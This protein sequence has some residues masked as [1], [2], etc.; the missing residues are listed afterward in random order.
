MLTDGGSSSSF[1]LVN[2]SFG[3]GNA[4]YMGMALVMRGGFN[5]T[6][7]VCSFLNSGPTTNG[8][9]T[10]PTLFRRRDTAGNN[11]PGKLV[12]RDA[13]F[14]G[15]GIHQDDGIHVFLE[16][17]YSQ[18]M[19]APLFS[20]TSGAGSLGGRIEFYDTVTDTSNQPVLANWTDTATG[21]GMSALV[22]LRNVGVASNEAGGV[23]G[24]LTGKPIFR[25]VL[26]I[27]S[28]FIGQ[29]FQGVIEIGQD[30]SG[31]YRVATPIQ[32]TR[33]L[34]GSGQAL[35]AGDFALHANWGSGAAVSAVTGTDL[36]WQITVTAAGTPGSNPTITLTFK[37]G[38]WTLAPI[39]STKQVG[40]TGVLTNAVTE[41]PTATTNV[42]TWNG[43]PVAAST[44]IF[45][46]IVMGR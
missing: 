3:T 13:H 1:E 29:N 24:N 6:F 21:A 17:I 7:K 28:L 34:L 16:H 2:F 46:S 5:Y 10:T 41:V 19:R 43:T 20:I 42:I 9:S 35:V 26:A 8:I 39:C 18:V 32:K 27:D 37:D 31:V 36:G 4:D 25:G 30:S 44:Y 11:P 14:S 38:T 33:R 22:T 15:R 45:A 40:G 12:I 23:P